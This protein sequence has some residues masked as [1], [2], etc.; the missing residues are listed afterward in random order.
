MA[1][2]DVTEAITV[3]IAAMVTRRLPL[4][5]QLVTATPTFVKVVRIVASTCAAVRGV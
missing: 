1:M 5:F 2:I 4:V 3:A